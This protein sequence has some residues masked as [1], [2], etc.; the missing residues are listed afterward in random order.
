VPAVNL[1]DYRGLHNYN[2]PAW[3]QRNAGLPMETRFYGRWR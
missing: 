3:S 1:E 2:P